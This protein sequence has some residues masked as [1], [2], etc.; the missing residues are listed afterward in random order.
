M[1]SNTRSALRAWPLVAAGVV[2]MVVGS[3]LTSGARPV[4]AGD[5]KG[6][7]Q[8]PTGP[9]APIEEVLHCPLAFAGLH[10][11]KDLPEYSQ[12]AYHYCK[13]LN[14]E[15]NQCVLYDGHGPD[16]RLIGVEYL[17][18]DRIYQAMPA[19][20]KAYWHD[21]K[22][23]VDAGLLKSLTQSGAD[24]K[25]TLAKVRTLWGK[26]YHTWASGKSYPSGPPRLFWSVT[27]VEPFT[28]PVG[29]KL[30]TEMARGAD[31]AAGG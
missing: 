14:D 1:K 21:H 26:V 27:G 9:K 8:R 24:E 15:V 20:E 23:E 13:P 30:P 7:A 12:V 10:L 3:V 28:L 25:A 16:A 19:E 2:G 11:L 17:V 31:R 4:A 6:H 5:D 18:S 29:A 22:Y